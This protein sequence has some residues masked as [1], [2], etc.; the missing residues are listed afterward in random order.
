MLKFTPKAK[1]NAYV[2]VDACN[3][4]RLLV[5]AFR[6]WMKIYDPDAI[7][8]NVETIDYTDPKVKMAPP[9]RTKFDKT[10]VLNETF[11][12]AALKNALSDDKIIAAV[13]GQEPG[14]EIADILSE[15]FSLPTSN[16]TA[17]SEARRNKYLMRK[18][19][20]AAGLSTPLFT[21]SNNYDEILAWAKTHASFPEKRVVL[22]AECDAGSYG[23]RICSTEDELRKYFDKLMNHT[24][25]MGEKNSFVL[26]ET[27][28][29]GPEYVINSESLHGKHYVIDIWKYEKVFVEG[30]GNIYDKE[31]LISPSSE[32]GQQLIA[33]NSEVLDA[34]SIAYGPTHL[35]MIMT[36]DGLELVKVKVKA[37]GPTLVEV[38]A[39]VSGVVNPELNDECIAPLQNQIDL[40][41]LCYIKPEYF[42]E[43]VCNS[44][45]EP[46][47]KAM[48]VNLINEDLEG[49]IVETNQDVLNKIRAIPS[50]L[51]LIL[52]KDVG[53]YLTPTED[54]MNSPM[55]LFMRADTSEQ[56]ERDYNALQELKKNLY[57]VS[58]YPKP[59]PVEAAPVS[60]TFTD[61]PPQNT[62]SGIAPEPQF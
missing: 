16:G 33:Y 47:Q 49:Y 26:A 35:E 27:F 18:A 48:V 45:C 58:P 50:V 1:P 43:V 5:G 11:D 59:K 56:L 17:K 42:E 2:L 52:R 29:E 8:I 36:K 25:I 34:L 10:Y 21:E 54:L 53:A 28:L 4:G 44:P 61:K 41:A 22:K 46:H 15:H 20:A 30:H 39:R 57:R 14:V 19:V 12:L 40:T 60:M 9:E 6:K 23:V 7:L 37:H 38:G 55:R 31:C 24:T 13:A 32:E 51:N 3:S 62:G